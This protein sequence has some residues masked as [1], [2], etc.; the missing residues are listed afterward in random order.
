MKFFGWFRNKA[1]PA[2]VSSDTFQAVLA[3]RGVPPTLLDKLEDVVESRA[4]KRIADDIAAKPVMTPR[5][6]RNLMS[7]EKEPIMSQLPMLPLSTIFMF[8]VYQSIEDYS[9]K[10]KKTSPPFDITREPQYWEDPNALLSTK[11]FVTYD[12]V[13]AVSENGT[14]LDDPNDPTRNAP[15]LT[16]MAYPK[17]IAGSVNIPVKTKDGLVVS[18]L[19]LLPEAQV[20]LDLSKIP[21]GYKIG[22]FLGNIQLVPLDFGTGVTTGET[23]AGEKLDSIQAGINELKAQLTRIEKKL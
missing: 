8:P 18:T 13:I 21:A 20:P 6:K 16:D 14:P 22:R 10:T 7:E 15:L 12:N 9:S 19:P 1:I 4:A 3:S 2:V 23:N 17:A 5:P 11:R